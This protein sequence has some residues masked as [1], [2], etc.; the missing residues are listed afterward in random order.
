MTDK[1][2]RKALK[3]AAGL[4]QGRDDT[5]GHLATGEIVI[6]IDLQKKHPE[7]VGSLRKAFA[8]SG[9]DYDRFVVG[10]GKNKKNTQ[11]K[12][13]MFD[14]GDGG[15]GGGDGGEG[16][17]G[18]GEGEGEGEGNSGEG[19]WGGNND[20]DGG[21][22]FGSNGEGQNGEGQGQGSE[23][24]GG[25]G[26]GGNNDGDGG[27]GFGSNGEG[28]LGNGLGGGWG[29]DAS[30]Q[31]SDPG[32]GWGGFTE[33]SMAGTY[34][35]DALS[36]Q[37]IADQNIDFVAPDP[38]VEIIN[39]LEPTSPLVNNTLQTV[40]QVDPQFEKEFAPEVITEKQDF[41]PSIPG[42]NL[43]APQA[44]VGPVG[45][46]PEVMAVYNALLQEN[47][48]K[49]AP[50][51]QSQTMA[52]A[53][54]AVN[55]QAPQAQ[56][57]QVAAN[58]PNF[59]SLNLNAFSTP[60]A[61]TVTAAPAATTTAAPAAAPTTAN[62]SPEF[63]TNFT[64]QINQ[65]AL[66]DLQFSTPSQNTAASA[67][68]GGPTAASSTSYGPAAPI[69]SSTSYTAS[70]SFLSDPLGWAAAK[71]SNIAN[72]P[73]EYAVNAAMMGVPV[74]GTLN[75]LSGLMGGPT[76]GGI[77]Q[78][79][80]PTGPED[81]SADLGGGGSSPRSPLSGLS[82]SGSTV[83]A[84]PTLG[85]VV[86][87]ISKTYLDA[88]GKLLPSVVDINTPL[89]TA[90]LTRKYLGLAN[91]PY[92]Y[93]FGGERAYYAEGG[94]VTAPNPPTQVMLSPMPTMAYTDGQG[95]VGAV[96]APP[97]LSP[98][99]TVGSD[100]PHASPTA[101]APAAAAPSFMPP[102]QRAATYNTN[103][104]PVAAPISQNPNLGYSLGMSPLARLAGMRNV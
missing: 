55:Q 90:A 104:S 26:W 79:G 12:A 31:S 40:T 36:S 38:T 82:S 29:D 96:A 30:N 37:S 13:P 52:Q 84:A 98:Y 74:V 77:M 35:F 95:S 16:G 62:V 101:P 65:T 73:A 83:A 89:G 80:T 50:L 45:Y 67:P 8:D 72:N 6:P 27:G 87:P 102:P 81:M 7:L 49:G 22:G 43:A 15:D 28:G 53:L 58:A 1:P 46:P 17:G 14:E 4:G 86:N 78:S 18:E 71:A 59:G 3:V 20:G 9:I 92:K 70:P 99:D 5:V 11:T 93:G 41:T 24:Q 47:A 2:I 103:A 68:Q 75:T 91:D 23:G 88:S 97:G 10:S 19:G 100:A 51:S 69:A 44:V 94:P 34:G 61:Q 48:N 64:N 60:T 76:I 21:G 63:W 39:A 85:A 56:Q 57:Q 25:G 42:L 54:A 32:S 33:G 66:N